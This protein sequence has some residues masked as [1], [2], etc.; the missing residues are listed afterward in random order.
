MGAAVPDDSSESV[1]DGEA[2]A[3]VEGAADEVTGVAGWDGGA[4]VHEVSKKLIPSQV[5]STAT[6]RR[7]FKVCS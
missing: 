1:V 3:N 5:A 7:F 4:G 2:G 6:A